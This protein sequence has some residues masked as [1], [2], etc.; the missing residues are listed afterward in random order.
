MKKKNPRSKKLIQSS[1]FDAFRFLKNST[2]ENEKKMWENELIRLNKELD[3]IDE[4]Y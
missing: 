1:W 4:L 3:K 2:D